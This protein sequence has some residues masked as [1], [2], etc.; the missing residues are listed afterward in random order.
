MQ[1]L[2]KASA[3]HG[4][5]V[6][7][8]MGL[9]TRAIFRFFQYQLNNTRPYS[10]QTA[11][12]AATTICQAMYDFIHVF[13]SLA[14]SAGKHGIIRFTL[15]VFGDWKQGCSVAWT[16][17]CRDAIALKQ[18]ARCHLICRLDRLLLPTQWL[19]CEESGRSGLDLQ[20]LRAG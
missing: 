15:R 10:L 13:S 18:R 9:H 19:N 14:R 16:L 1:L 17:H 2:L 20:R 11:R 7:E 8:G 5:E 4:R 3:S 6:C 12:M